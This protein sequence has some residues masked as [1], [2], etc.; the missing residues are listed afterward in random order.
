VN[1]GAP[2]IVMRRV[3]Q[4][5][6]KG[7]GVVQDLMLGAWWLALL[8]AG[9]VFILTED[10]TDA[11]A[12]RRNSNLIILGDVLLIA[13]AGLLCFLMRGVN[14]GIDNPDPSRRLTPGA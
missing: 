9:F 1:L 11:E 7:E 10:A 13:S 2:L 6:A 3:V 8:V 5:T 12:W 14:V 4:A